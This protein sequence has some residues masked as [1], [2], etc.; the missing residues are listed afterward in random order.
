MSTKESL[1][2]TAYE[3]LTERYA[4]GSIDRE[5]GF[6]FAALLQEA[7]AR[8][9]L[10]SEEE[11]SKVASPFYT[12]LTIDGRFVNKGNNSWVL[13]EHELFE[14]VHIDMNDAY[15]SDEYEQDDGNNTEELGEE[16]DYGHVESTDDDEEGNVNLAS[17][18]NDEDDENN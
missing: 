17:H 11:L 3:I 14:N 4:D 15:V 10:E 6:S 8:I 16:E 1:V 12:S 9:G 2:D 5:K 18:L 13:R 7:G